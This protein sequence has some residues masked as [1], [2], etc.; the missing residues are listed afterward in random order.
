MTLE[1]NTSKKQFQELINSID[2]LENTNIIFTKT[3]SDPDGK[4]INL[5]IDDYTL[6]NSNKSI[7]IASLGQLNYLSALQFMDFIIGNSSS[8]LIEAPSFKI[9]TVN[10]GDRQRGRINAKSVVNCLPDKK[11]IKVAIKK[12][13]SNEFQKLLKNVKNPYENGCASKKVS[14]IL[15]SITLDGILKKKFFNIKF[16]I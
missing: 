2:D 8:G 9:G 3:N 12:I 6:N 15:K 13:Y 16:S 5:M 1:N 7:G 10:I 11:S 14:N 4:I